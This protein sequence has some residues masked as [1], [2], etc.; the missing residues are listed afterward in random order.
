MHA[1][2]VGKHTNNRSSYGERAACAPK[3]THTQT[4][5]HIL[6]HARALK[7]YA[8]GGGGGGRGGRGP[9]ARVSLCTL[10]ARIIWVPYSNAC[11]AHAPLM[12][13]R[14]LSL[15]CV[16]AHVDSD[17]IIYFVIQFCAHRRTHTSTVY[18]RAQACVEC[19]SSVFARVRNSGNGRAEGCRNGARA[20]HTHRT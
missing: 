2:A 4:L 16:C 1:C 19:F 9:N 15:R 20:T 18:E 3:H 14:L 12:Y 10:L 13:K 7:L 17:I 5:A 11:G 8:I 6:F